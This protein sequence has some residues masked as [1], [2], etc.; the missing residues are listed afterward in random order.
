MVLQPWRLFFLISAASIRASS[1]EYELY[2][3]HVADCTAHL[4]AAL[5][6][7]D[8]EVDRLHAHIRRLADLFQL[9]D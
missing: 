9:A 6:V 4:R 7:S 8:Q 3:Q 2:E 5:D 1:D